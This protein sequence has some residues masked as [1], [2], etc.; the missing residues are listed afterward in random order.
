MA[1]I[2]EED[3]NYLTKEFEKMVN[4][5]K[6]VFFTQKFE[7]QYCELT[8]E[9][10][11]ELSELSDKINV[12]VY[13]FVE[14]KE[15]AEQYNIAR[16]PAIV[17]EGEKDYGI[18]FYGVPAGYEFSTLV[19]DIIDVSKGTTTLADETKEALKKLEKPVH[20]QVFI[21][22]TCP[23]CPRA[24]RMAHQMAMESEL[25][26]GDMVEAS[27][28]PQLSN[29]YGVSAVPKI[30]INENVS[31]EGALPEANYLEK[32]LEGEGASKKS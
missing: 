13:D 2:Q 28:Y 26:T 18:R 3:R 15:K 24:V 31:F 25:V 32:V 17:V 9:L 1:H 4:P 19:E 6:L 22:L 30:V 11:G 20:I 7:C 16:I 12:E 23:Y 5:V 27:E 14:N 21:T 10:L 29:R 8:H